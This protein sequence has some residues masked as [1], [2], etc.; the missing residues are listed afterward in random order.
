MKLIVGLGNP[1]KKYENTRHNVG[2]MAIDQLA[3]QFEIEGIKVN[4]QKK[5][6]S[7]FAK[8]TF[9]GE[10]VLLLKPQTYMNLSGKAVREVANFFKLSNSDI[11]VIYDDM[12]LK[13][14]VMKIKPKGSSGGQKGMQNIIDQFKTQEIARMKIGIGRPEND[15]I[16]HVLAA[17]DKQQQT[18]ITKVLVN[19]SNACLT[20]ISA[21]LQTMMTEWNGKDVA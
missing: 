10:T 20:F 12:D 19:A 14:S 2:F 9:N 3:K 17:F 5:F 16:E 15:T 11:L 1:G 7:E 21:D 13:V 6:E 8:L 18:I 4:W